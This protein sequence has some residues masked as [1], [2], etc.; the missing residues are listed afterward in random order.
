MTATL[1]TC[2][3]MSGQTVWMPEMSAAKSP[4]AQERLC[5]VASSCERARAKRARGHVGGRAWERERERCWESGRENWRAGERARAMLGQAAGSSSTGLEV[6]VDGGDGMPC[7]MSSPML[8]AGSMFLLASSL[9]RTLARCALA[10]SALRSTRP[11]RSG[12]V[13]AGGHV[14]A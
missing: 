8:V 2:W 6:C 4:R 5:Q 11:P 3:C 13:E 12:H 7:T 14:C 10:P 1:C 9:L